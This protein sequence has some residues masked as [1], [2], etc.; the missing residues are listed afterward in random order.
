MD[1]YE[2]LEYVKTDLVKSKGI[3]YVKFRLASSALKAKEDIEKNNYMVR[4]PSCSQTVWPRHVTDSVRHRWSSSASNDHSLLNNYICKE[5]QY[6]YSCAA[7]ESKCS[8]PSPNATLHMTT[9]DMDK[10]ERMVHLHQSHRSL[11]QRPPQTDLLGCHRH[12]HFLTSRET[13]SSWHTF[14]TEASIF[15]K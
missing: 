5:L 15:S 7:N 9:L 11:V 14:L 6:V 2:G 12:H 10:R 13:L 8:K 4:D 3:I 1:K